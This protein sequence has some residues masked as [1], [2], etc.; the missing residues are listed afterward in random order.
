[1]FDFFRSFLTSI[2]CL[3]CSLG[4]FL[5]FSQNE[6]DQINPEVLT[7]KLAYQESNT[8]YFDLI[9]TKLDVSFDWEKQ[10]LFGKANLILKPYFFEQKELLLDAKGM[11]VVKVKLVEN[12]SESELNFEYDGMQIAVDLVKS[13]TRKDTIEI[14]IE[15]VAKPNEIVIKGSE[16]ITEDKGLYFINP[17]GK[18]PN[19][20]KQIWT[21]GETEASSVW[22]PTIDKPN[23]RCTQEISI[24]I[25]DNFN[26]LSNGILTQQIKNSNGTRTDTWVMDQPH[27]P[28]L[29]MMSIGEYAVTKD[30]WNKIPLAYHVEPKFEDHAKSIFGRTPEM[31]EFFSEMLD[32]PFPWQNYDQ[33]VVRDY[34]SGAME[35]TTSSVFMESLQ[36]TKREL[37]DFNW[38]DIIAHELFHQWFGDLVTCESWS[39]LTLN[40]GF[41]SYSEYLWNEHKYGRD[42]ADYNLM[43][44][45]EQYFG[46]AV[47]EP[48]NL[49][50]YY[51]DD[52]ENMFDSHS[53]NKGA[54]VLHMLRNYLGDEAFFLGLNKYLRDNA[55]QSVELA[56]LRMAFEAICG[57]DLNWF[58]NQWFFHPGHPVIEVKHNYEKDTLTVI[59]TQIQ[60]NKETPIYEL[61]VFIDVWEG[62]ESTSYPV[63][64]KEA[65]EVYQFKMIEEPDLV[66]FDSERQLLAEISHPLSD[67][68]LSFQIKNDLSLYGRM[69][70]IDSLYKIKNK[71]LVGEIL[72]EAF[73]DPY[74]II[75]QYAIEYLIENKV[76]IK[77]YQESIDDLILDP[78]SFVRAMALVYVGQE[79]PDNYK[80]QIK[81]ALKDS[82]YLVVGSA[83][84]QWTENEWILEE[85]QLSSFSTE[86]NI[87]IILP[88]G[89][90]Y[91][92]Q[93]DEAS[94]KWFEEKIK[95]VKN[96]DL[97][98]FLQIYSEKLINAPVKYRRS[99]TN[100]FFDAALN[101]SNYT[102]R[103]SGYQGLLLLTDIEGVEDLLRKVKSN[104]K[105]ERLLELYDQL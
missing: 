33:V 7:S 27:A 63:V 4:S 29:F 55:Y 51:Y 69:E 91:G 57:E 105:D 17:L 5:A 36:L 97:Y 80:E 43:E 61:P 28:Y 45:H 74:Y 3:G 86:T 20:P 60:E 96:E 1:M 68:E 83:L 72:N 54:A 23:E 8:R 66:I 93:T 92:K 50:R 89:M 2:L 52:K 18:D 15:Y 14:Y 84:T 31:M 30:Q 12:K 22:F 21:Q 39:N 81:N 41:A 103:F 59:V 49:L 101:N 38:D 78:S 46:E 90:Y 99:A 94:F 42:E 24:T 79:D 19:K 37:I 26:T 40:E 76:K 25:E 98:Y 104:E 34:V 95:E 10:F 62:T 13:Y 77:K 70:T 32:Y 44:D 11:S 48:K 100:H 75:R 35:N 53:Y 9:H 88:I 73:K 16:A 102:A 64:L 6:E 82:S 47:H 58:F 56:N 87:N 85:E 67:K 65:M 71:K